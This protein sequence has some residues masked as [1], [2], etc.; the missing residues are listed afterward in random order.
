M[1][2]LGSSIGTSGVQFSSSDLMP[3]YKALDKLWQTALNEE[4]L[5]HEW[6]QMVKHEIKD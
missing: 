2:G 1:I 6:Q 4:I 5:V 3:G